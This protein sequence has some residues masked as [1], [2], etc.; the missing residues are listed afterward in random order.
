MRGRRG[1]FITLEGGEGSGKSVQVEALGQLLAEAGQPALLTREPAG[2][3]LGRFLWSLFQSGEGREPIAMTPVAELF[4]FEAARAQHVE[5]AVRPAL[6]EGRVVLC[7]RFTDSTLA[8]QG[9][10]R[11]LSLDYIRAANHMASGGLA[12][13][14]TLLLD[15]P[16]EV[17]LSRA[18][19]RSGGRDDRIGQEDAE[20]HSRVREGFLALARREPERFF[21][22]DATKPAD[23]V[24]QRCWEQV[25]RLLDRL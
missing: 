25:R 23:E 13:D 9:Y 24:T 7:E 5:D 4:L 10:G 8:Y 6:E 14:L 15:V 2:T 17:G 11:G 22:V 3:D 18:G 12:P 1:P 21:V 20:F 19:N 16:P